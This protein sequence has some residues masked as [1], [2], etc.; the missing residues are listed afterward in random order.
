MEWS[1]PLAG[2]AT[3]DLCL[4]E[5]RNP[6]KLSEEGAALLTM[7][8]SV[9]VTCRIV[10]E[11]SVFRRMALIGQ[12]DRPQ[13]ARIPGRQLPAGVGLPAALASRGPAQIPEPGLRRR[14][15]I[16][17]LISSAPYA[18][19]SGALQALAEGWPDDATLCSS[20]T[21][22]PRTSTDSPAVPRRRRWPR[23]GRTTP[24]ASPICPAAQ[25]QHG[26]PAAPRCGRWPRDGRTTPLW[27]SSRTAAQDQHGSAVRLRCGRWPRDGRTTPLVVLLT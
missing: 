8:C 11:K 1:N 6:A 4:S 20:P 5:V 17:D 19:R 26:V 13:L 25:D 14:Q 18:V 21:A 9:Q 22:P 23:H 10:E 3:G 24:S 15:S 7:L 16:V 27:C 2:I 12:G